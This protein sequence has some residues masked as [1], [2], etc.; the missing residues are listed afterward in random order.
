MD[1]I[2]NGIEFDSRVIE[3]DGNGGGRFSQ[4]AIDRFN[5]DMEQTMREIRIQEARSVKLA[6]EIVLTD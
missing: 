3:N 1:D 6:E 4:E 5:K 2:M